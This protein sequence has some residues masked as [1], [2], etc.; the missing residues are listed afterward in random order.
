MRAIKTGHTIHGRQRNTG[1]NTSL[2]KAA[3]LCYADTFVINQSL[4]LCFKPKLAG[5]QA[6]SIA[7][8]K[9]VCV[10]NQPSY[11]RSKNAV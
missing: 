9:N 1:G 10:L 8:P 2:A 11:S 4:V 3:V 6:A 7:K 5:W